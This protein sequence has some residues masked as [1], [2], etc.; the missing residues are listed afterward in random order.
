[1]CRGRDFT[2]G[3]GGT[4]RRSIAVLSMAAVLT[5]SCATPYVPYLG[6]PAA[7]LRPGLIGDA[8]L[9]PPHITIRRVQAPG[10]CA[11]PVTL[12]FFAP[13]A[14]ASR[15]TSSSAREA[16]APSTA[17]GSDPAVPAAPPL[18]QG[19]PEFI[20]APGLYQFNVNLSAGVT[21]CSLAGTIELTQ[22]QRQELIAVFS[23]QGNSCH[24]A[25]RRWRDG[26]WHAEPPQP[27]AC[28][29]ARLF[30]AP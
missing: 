3:T 8:I 26:G 5:A 10:T 20:V 23:A 27:P 17:S 19:Q 30:S 1:M 21:A 9:K 13:Q 24:V 2:A 6:Q 15:A 14:T 12:S 25:L 29:E 18:G 16:L 7:Y 11:E 22:Q 28:N 4:R